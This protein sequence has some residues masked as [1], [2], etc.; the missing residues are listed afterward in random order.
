MPVASHIELRNTRKTTVVLTPS[1]DSKAYL[2][3]DPE[4]AEDGGDSMF[5]ERSHAMSPAC[6]NAVR[7]GALVPVGL[8][9]EDALVK[10]Y[11]VTPAKAKARAKRQENAGVRALKVAFDEEGNQTVTALR[12]SV[13]PLQISHL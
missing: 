4:G 8:D 6:V 7:G 1:P 13:E 5:V 2:R 11:A 10:V 9:P 12:V 3:W